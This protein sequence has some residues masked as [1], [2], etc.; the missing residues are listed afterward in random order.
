[1]PPDSLDARQPI[2]ELLLSLRAGRSEAMTR[3]F[4][5]V[6]DELRRI[7]HCHLLGQGEGHTLGTTGLVHEAYLRL[8]DQ[9]RVEWNDRRHFY[10]AAS[11]AMRHILV[12]HARR[13]YAVK[14]G[15]GR[16]VIELVEG[17]VAVEERAELLVALDEAL[18]R[19][20]A[21]DERLGRVVECR[22]FAGLSEE[23]TAEVL[24]VTARTVRRD[25]TKAKGWLYRELSA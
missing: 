21:L 22:F 12:D 6:Y 19:L 8:A 3:L 14:R 13:H 20:E 11:R 4:P 17:T 5:L 10:A 7:A 9:T 25:W 18:Q 24:G 15:G 1:M 2:T 23:E 16:P